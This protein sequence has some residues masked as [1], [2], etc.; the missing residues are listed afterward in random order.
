MVRRHILTKYQPAPEPTC[1]VDHAPSE[2]GLTCSRSFARATSPPTNYISSNGQLYVGSDHGSHEDNAATVFAADRLIA[3]KGTERSKSFALKRSCSSRNLVQPC[4]EHNCEQPIVAVGSHKSCESSPFKTRPCHEAQTFVHHHHHDTDQL[5]QRCEEL[6]CPRQHMY[7]PNQSRYFNA[8]DAAASIRTALQ[9]GQHA[10]ASDGYCQ[11][12]GAPGGMC[13]SKNRSLERL[14]VTNPTPDLYNPSNL[15]TFR[16]TPR[17]CRPAVPQGLATVLGPRMPKGIELQIQKRAPRGLAAVVVDQCCVE[18]GVLHQQQEQEQIEMQEEAQEQILKMEEKQQQLQMLQQQQDL[19]RQQQELQHQQQLQQ[20]LLMQQQQLQSQQHQLGQLK[21][22]QLEDE[23]AACSS[24]VSIDSCSDYNCE[25]FQPLEPPLR[26]TSF[27]LDPGLL[28]DDDIRSLA[29]RAGSKRKRLS[30][31]SSSF[32]EPSQR[33]QLCDDPNHLRRQMERMSFNENTIKS[34][35]SLPRDSLEGYSSWANQAPEIPAMSILRETSNQQNSIDFDDNRRRESSKASV[36]SFHTSA[37]VSSDSG[38]STS[39]C[40]RPAAGPYAESNIR[41]LVQRAVQ[42]QLNMQKAVQDAVQQEMNERC[43]TDFED[44]S[45]SEPQRFGSRRS[46]SPTEVY[47]EQVATD[48][49]NAL[50]ILDQTQEELTSKI[51]SKESRT[52]SRTSISRRPSASTEPSRDGW[53]RVSVTSSSPKTGSVDAS[54]SRSI[55]GAQGQSTSQ[56]AGISYEDR[57]ASITQLLNSMNSITQLLNSMPVRAGDEPQVGNPA[58]QQGSTVVAQRPS[59]IQSFNMMGGGNPQDQFPG[60]PGT[61][62][63]PMPGQQPGDYSQFGG[64]PPG[65]F[66]QMI[67]GSQLPGYS[68]QVPVGGSFSAGRRSSYGRQSRSGSMFGE[69]RSSRRDSQLGRRRSS[70]KP[71]EVTDDASEGSE[72]VPDEVQGEGGEEGETEDLQQINEEGG[73]EG[74]EEGEGEQGEGEQSEGSQ[75]EGMAAIHQSTSSI[76]SQTIIID[77]MPQELLQSQLVER[78]N[79]MYGSSQNPKPVSHAIMPQHSD[80]TSIISAAQTVTQ[81]ERIKPADV[82][83]TPHKFQSFGL[84]FKPQTR[85]KKSLLSIVYV[86]LQELEVLESRSRQQSAAYGLTSPIRQ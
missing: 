73:E 85:G 31:R 79:L 74:G 78:L 4:P 29:L 57:M 59:Q 5:G 41:N 54:I 84:D 69:R 81:I 36:V 35:R 14:R 8:L 34:W 63:I 58:L 60:Q 39:P 9:R 46:L 22:Q 13:V 45:E 12:T 68:V 51:R 61:R 19:F 26:S 3:M 53:T 7:N 1:E 50:D 76:Q 6:S 27:S 62:F 20:Q 49:R 64:V 16:F 77:K 23:E 82:A 17:C 32:T 52:T 24:A 25:E 65:S 70:A 2:K 21:Q 83:L 66:N 44:S 72:A 48:A 55:D 43:T 47:A 11:S 18:T 42:Q 67:P 80:R 33:R 37:G 38:R 15:D 86:M 30:M 40:R 56:P 71:P 75:A 28:L 10:A